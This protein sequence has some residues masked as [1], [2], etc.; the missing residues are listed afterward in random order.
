MI[1]DH[2]S[3][4][5]APCL[6]YSHFPYTLEEEEFL[7]HMFNASEEEIEEFQDRV[8]TISTLT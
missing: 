8:E 5:A 6:N 1:G 4:G 2:S 7:K 3:A